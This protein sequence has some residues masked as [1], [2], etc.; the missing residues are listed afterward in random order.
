MRGALLLHPYGARCAFLFKFAQRFGKSLEFLRKFDGKIFQNG[1][2]V[3]C[4][5]AL[6]FGAQ[7]ERRSF[8][9]ITC[10]RRFVFLVCWLID[11][12]GGGETYDA[13]KDEQELGPSSRCHEHSSYWL[14][15]PF[16][17][18]LVSMINPCAG[19]SR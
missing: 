9:S 16:A 8:V 5:A 15:E 17:A 6:L 1:D 18:K 13:E 10:D 12:D 19:D 11:E 14:E 4:R 3:V 2:F 7:K